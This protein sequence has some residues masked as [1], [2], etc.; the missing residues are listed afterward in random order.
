[1]EEFEEAIDIQSPYVQHPLYREAMRQVTEGNPAEAVDALVRLAELYPN[2]KAVQDLLLRAQLR[3]TFGGTDYIPVERPKP[4]PVLRNVVLALLAVTACM[5]VITAFT[6]V[7]NNVYLVRVNDQEREAH[8]Q[9]LWAEFQSRLDSGDV[10]GARE[11]LEELFTLTPNEPALQDALQVV[12]QR[13]S[14]ADLYAEASASRERGDWQQA[15]ELAS[16]VP[17]ESPEYDAA[18]RLIQEVQESAQLEASWQ[19][20]QGLLAA[21]DWRAAI[22]ILEG[23]RFQRPDFRRAEVEEQLFQ[24]NARTARQLID[25]ANGNVDMLREAISFLNDA[26]TL[27]PTHRELITERDLA[28]G[29]VN[30]SDALNRG[31]W[32]VVVTSW[33]SVYG[34][35]PDYQGGIVQRR[36]DEAY[37]RAATQLIAQAGGSERL[38]RQAVDYLDQALVSNPDDA[39]LI[40]ERRLALEYLAGLEEFVKEDWNGAIAHWGPIWLLRPDYQNGALDAKLDTACSNSESPDE[41][42]CSP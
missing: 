18:Q 25:Q 41:T 16:Q 34:T 30:G 5:V 12:E 33:Q 13:E 7:Y 19:Q 21:E 36:L 31:D 32:V 10:I 15:I 8:I 1:M 23:I 2:E 29:F 37:P 9:S 38:L 17:P 4:T 39:V 11:I 3:T 22:P 14:W 40:E 35:R 26:L 27:Q 6:Y 20:A 24:A 42:F 28:V